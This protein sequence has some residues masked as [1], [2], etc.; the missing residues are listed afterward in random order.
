LAAQALAGTEGTEVPFWSPDSRH[1]AFVAGGKLRRIE[2]SGGSS[3]ILCD[4][5][6]GRGGSWS[7]DGVIVF[8]P[9]LA[10][11]IQRVAATGGVPAPVTTVDPARGETSHRWPSFLPDG[12]HFVYMA[13]GGP[14]AGGHPIYVGSLDGGPPR[15][16]LRAASNAAFA[17]PHHLLFVA[18]GNLMAQPLDVERQALAGDAVPVGDD[19]LSAPSSGMATFSASDNGVLAYQA[20]GAGEGDQLAS[21]DRQG[22]VGETLPTPGQ[23]SSPRLSPDG[24][25]IALTLFDPRNDTVDLWIRDLGRKVATRFTADPADETFPVWSPDGSRIVYSS[26]RGGK[27]GDLYVKPSGGG[28]EEELL[29]SDEKKIPTS[30]SPDGRHILYYTVSPKTRADVW[31]LSV[32]DRKATPLLQTEFDESEAEFSPDGRWIAY[33]SGESGGPDVFVRSFP[34]GDGRWQVST[35]TGKMPRWRADGKELFYSGQDWTLMAV[36]VKPGGSAFEAGPPRA[37][38]LARMRDARYR[39]YDVSADGQR[40]VV[41]VL[42]L[43]ENPAPLTLVLNWMAGRG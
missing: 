33:R 6:R 40:F 41:S 18:H 38:F 25:R 14:S 3:Q 32:A 39:Q 7:R 5:A 37:L 4:A 27:A 21:F 31:V 34:P 1:L 36:D 22:L 16:L 30:W 23:H 35:S 13:W 11:P 10:S 26:T 29:A 19:V 17:P 20:G 43:A 15:L 9:D 28:P 2:V 8:A 42:S 12:R 24:Q